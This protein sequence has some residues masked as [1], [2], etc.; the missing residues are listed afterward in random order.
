ML[1]S[2]VRR[3]VKEIKEYFDKI[4]DDKINEKNN[5]NEQIYNQI[6]KIKKKLHK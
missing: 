5:Q 1:L 2:E 4:K 3:E 6:P